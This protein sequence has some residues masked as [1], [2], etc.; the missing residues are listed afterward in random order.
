VGCR[1][2]LVELAD[3]SGLEPRLRVARTLAGRFDAVLIGMHVMPP[4]FVPASS[5]E[6]AA[7][8]GPELIEAQRKANREIAER[9]QALFRSVCGQ[10]SNAT[11][12]EAEG[13][14]GQLLAEAAHATD[15]VLASG[16]R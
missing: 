12:Q 15:L 4:P 2:I 5:G 14:R 8:L 16:R 13:D 3:D 7:Y 11:W 9:V 6:A 10:E 1:T